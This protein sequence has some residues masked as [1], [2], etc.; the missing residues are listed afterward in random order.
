M[1]NLSKQQKICGFLAI[2]LSI[3]QC[4]LCV[5]IAVLHRLAQIKVGVNRHVV[6]KRIQYSK[7][8]LNETGLNIIFVLSLIACLI[9][10]VVMVRMIKN[11]GYKIMIFSLALAIILAIG[12]M[13]EVKLPSIQETPIYI[14]LLLATAIVFG[15][16]LVKCVIFKCFKKYRKIE[17]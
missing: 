2:I 9:L 8:I 3:V 13:L 11:G 16:E 7:G 17:S 12:I 6:Y 14:Y 15:I 4:L 5:A 10:I 1:L